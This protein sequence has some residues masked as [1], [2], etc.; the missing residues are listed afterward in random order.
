MGRWGTWIVVWIL[1][2]TVVCSSRIFCINR[3]GFQECKAGGESFQIIDESSELPAKLQSG[4]LKDF[5][6]GNRTISCFVNPKKQEC[7]LPGEKGITRHLYRRGAMDEGK[8][9]KILES[10]LNNEIQESP[11]APEAVPTTGNQPINTARGSFQG[12]S[13]S[14]TSKDATSVKQEVEREKIAT[15]TTLPGRVVS[16]TVSNEKEKGSFTHTPWEE[17]PPKQR[18]LGD[19]DGDGVE[20][21]LVWRKSVSKEIGDFYQLS[22]YRK[23]GRLLWQSP[24]SMNSDDPYAFGSWDFGE[25]LPE[26]LADIDGDGQAELLA[27]A[28]T[29]DVSPVYYRIFGWNGHRLIPRRPAVLMCSRRERDRFVWVNPYPGDGT[30]GCWVSSLHP[31]DSSR[32]AVAEL[33]SLSPQGAKMGK[34]RVRFDPYGAQI[35]Q[36]IEPLSSVS[37]SGETSAPNQYI[38]RIG[39]QDHYNSRGRRLLDLRAILHQDRANYY[40]GRGD[41]QDT[42]IGVFKTPAQRSRIDRMRVEGVNLSL[43]ELR[44][45]VIDSTPLLRITVEPDRLRIEKIGE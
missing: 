28:P 13:T 37:E 1:M 20:D 23:D 27:P 18:L 3:R 38:A 32:E 5:R 35:V 15:P 43:R 12:V 42:G 39:N 7:L 16:I 11:P 22:I 4:N 45:S 40:K 19:I 44:R 30:E 25:S 8:I 34:A 26:V 36:W 14:F 31:V 17:I 10:I 41:P 6:I 24:V 2:A 29:S 33:T 21:V 9:T